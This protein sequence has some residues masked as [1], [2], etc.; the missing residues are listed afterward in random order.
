MLVDAISPNK[1]ALVSLN[2]LP[3][4]F[5]LEANLAEAPVFG[6]P[7]RYQM[8]IMDK[9]FNTSRNY[10]VTSPGGRPSRMAFYDLCNHHR[11]L[12]L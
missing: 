1:Q 11:N 7:L 5:W 6:I 4:R 10:F 3:H 2:S 8:A 12:C 9:G